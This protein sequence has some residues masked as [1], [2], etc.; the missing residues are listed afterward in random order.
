MDKISEMLFEALT[1]GGSLKDLQVT[2]KEYA[3]KYPVSL[4][5]ALRDQP[6]FRRMWTA[7]AEACEYEFQMGA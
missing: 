5:R 7:M 1:S 4:Q 2:M 6:A 3:D